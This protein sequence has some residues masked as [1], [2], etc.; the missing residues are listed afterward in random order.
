MQ[1][2]HRFTERFGHMMSRILL[3]LLYALLV[4]PAGLVM[5]LL[6][7]PLRIKK[8]RGSS[9]APW[10]EDNESLERARRQD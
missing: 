2:L 5:A 8:Y 10:N 3:T 6:C 1:R 4:A 9:W 7:D